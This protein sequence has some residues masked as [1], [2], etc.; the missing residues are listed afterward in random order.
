MNKLLRFLPLLLL[1]SA[2]LRAEEP[3]RFFVE[4]IDVRNLRHA[5]REVIV[6]EARL[7]EGGAYSEAELREANDRI[8]RLPFVLDAQFSLEK[9]SRRD[10]YVLVISV[11]ETKPF[12]YGIDM[13]LFHTKDDAV[14]AVPSDE[15]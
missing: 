2:P 11:E 9:G 5:G 6:S 13:T 7:H 14:Q 15:R 12:F 10:A 4:R 1:L 8:E 3:V